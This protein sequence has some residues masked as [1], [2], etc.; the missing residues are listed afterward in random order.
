MIRRRDFFL[1]AFLGIVF[2]FSTP[3][4]AQTNIA[5]VANNARIAIKSGSSKE[6]VK[7]FNKKIELRLSKE[8]LYP[9]KEQS[10]VILR[11]FFEAN[12]P[13]NI[14]YTFNGSA[15][16]SQHYYYIWNLACEGNQQYRVVAYIKQI[17]GQF[18]ID[19]LHFTPQ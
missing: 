14:E 12:R 8:T 15:P 2:A 1:L 3:V 7:Y 6:L 11:D 4:L 17:N 13:T 18:L 9:G 5:D 10:E 16:E 19:R